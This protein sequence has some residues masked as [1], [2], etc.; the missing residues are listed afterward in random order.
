[1][2]ADSRSRSVAPALLAVQAGPGL[3]M[4]HEARV[5][6]DRLRL[7][8]EFVVVYWDQRGCGV[9]QLGYSLFRFTS[10]DGRRHTRRSWLS[11]LSEQPCRPDFGATVAT[12]R[13]RAAD[14]PRGL[15][16]VGMDIDLNAGEREAYQFATSEA[17]STK[18]RHAH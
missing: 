15:I 5:F 11:S 18:R 1:V 17:L 10:T 4:I 16:T 13:P 9:V 6:E 2:V 12:L 7:E 3:P 14:A 8:N